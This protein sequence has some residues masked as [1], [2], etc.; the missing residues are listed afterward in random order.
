[1]KQFL[2]L[3][4]FAL[5]VSSTAQRT[6]TVIGNGTATEKP[7][8]ATFTITLFRSA[9]IAESQDSLILALQSFGITRSDIELVLKMPS[10]GS[11]EEE[12]YP[13]SLLQRTPKRAKEPI[14]EALKIGD[15]TKEKEYRH[16]YR[17]TVRNMK[18]LPV[19]IEMVNE[20][21]IREQDLAFDVLDRNAFERKAMQLALENARM[22]AEYLAT[23]V[24]ATLGEVDTIQDSGA[25]RNLFRFK[26]SLLNEKDE[27]VTESATI[28]VTYNLK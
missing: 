28:H 21:G 2:L 20:A 23:Q 12:A 11:D 19:I 17:I 18:N 5:P 13:L 3:I 25:D 22:R 26:S 1:M 6:I 27:E 7:E 24:K 10:A 16:K 4:L 8:I 9:Q 15:D 14:E